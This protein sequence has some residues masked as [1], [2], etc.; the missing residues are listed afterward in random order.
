MIL[1]FHIVTDK[2]GSLKIK[3]FEEFTDSQ[4]Y[5]DFFQAIAAAKVN[6]W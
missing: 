6:K 5:L 4:P 2:D 1:I 3:V